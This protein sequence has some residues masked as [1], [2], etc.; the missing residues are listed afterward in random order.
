MKIFCDFRLAFIERQTGFTRN[1]LKINGNPPFGYS[2]NVTEK[3]PGNKAF[4]LKVTLRITLY[5]TLLLRYCNG[6]E[7][8]IKKEKEKR[9]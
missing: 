3:T 6:T 2:K 1:P 9:F 4:A 5:N 8:D 7:E